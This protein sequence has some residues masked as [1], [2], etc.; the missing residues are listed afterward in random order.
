MI[1]GMA[2]LNRQKCHNFHT[3]SHVLR[4]T[5]AWCHIMFEWKDMLNGWAWSM[6]LVSFC[7]Y[8]NYMSQRSLARFTLLLVIDLWR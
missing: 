6:D 8:I 3:D 2:A 7:H 5:R 4:L 1:A